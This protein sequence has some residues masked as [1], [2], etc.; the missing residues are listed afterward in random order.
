MEARVRIAHRDGAEGRRG[1]PA[2]RL[3]ATPAYGSLSVAVQYAM[4]VESAFTLPPEPF[5]P[6]PKVTSTVVRLIRRDRR[7]RWR[8]ATS[9][10]SGR[11]CAARSR[12]GAKRSSTRSRWR[13]VWTRATIAR[14]L[15]CSNLSPE[16]RGERLDTRRLRPAG[17]RAGRRI[18]SPAFGRGSSPAFIAAA[19][20]AP[21][22]S[23]ASSSGRASADHA[24]CS[25]DILHRLAVLARRQPRRD[26]AR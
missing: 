17:R 25:F 24:R 20:R 4:H 3:P 6:A 18:A 12:T 10:L 7:R 21:H 23:A 14:A 26:R 16:L 19:H 5:Y 2:A 9:P 22:L 11:S 15:D 1:T 13:S 8:R